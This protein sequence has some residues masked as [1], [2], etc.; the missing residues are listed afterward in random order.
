[1]GPCGTFT[2]GVLEIVEHLRRTPFVHMGPPPFVH[3]GSAC[4]RMWNYEINYSDVL[5]KCS[6]ISRS[7]FVFMKDVQII[8]KF[9]KC[10][11]PCEGRENWI[12]NYGILP[13]RTDPNDESLMTWRIHMHDVTRVLAILR[14]I[15][16]FPRKHSRWMTNHSWHDASICVTWLVS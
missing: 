15:L 11:P 5:R 2:N 1:M 7:P 14:T 8:L 9:A 4:Q 6:T 10:V 3:M 12:T 16:Q 13:V